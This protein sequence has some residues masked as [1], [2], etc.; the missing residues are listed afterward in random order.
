MQIV[1]DDAVEYRAT[2][3]FRTRGTS[4][5]APTEKPAANDHIAFK[6][7]LSGPE[8]APENYTLMMSRQGAFYSP[9]HKHNFDQF[10]FAVS[11]DFSIGRGATLREGQLGYFPEGTPY[12][13]QD[14][15]EGQR[16]LLV[17]QFGGTSGQGYLSQQQLRAATGA[18]SAEGEFADGHFV[19]TGETHKKDAFEAVWEHHNRRPME[20]PPA[21]YKTPVM[22]TPS[23]FGWTETGVQGVRRK[24]L[25]TFTERQTRAEMVQADAGT[26][27]AFPAEDA[28]RLIYALSGTGTGWEARTAFALEPGESGS[29]GVEAAAEFIVFVLPRLRHAGA[30]VKAVA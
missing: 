27:C 16:E 21:R 26:T 10:R 23:H 29:I 15:G 9:A 25:G 12:G 18:L 13:P 22:M 3:G 17:L 11:G 2:P 20:Y 14:D 30:A 24:P 28:F 19:R 7:Y 1:R 6:V 4:R 8:D 5:G